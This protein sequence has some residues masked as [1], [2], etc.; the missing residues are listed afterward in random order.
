MNPESF[1]FSELVKPYKKCIPE[2]VEHID[3]LIDFVENFS[4]VFSVH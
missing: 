2:I 3:Y 4:Y 1:V